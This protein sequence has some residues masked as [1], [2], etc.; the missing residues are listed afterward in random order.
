MAAII[1]APTRGSAAI[2]VHTRGTPTGLLTPSMGPSFWAEP[3]ARSAKNRVPEKHPLRVIRRVVNEVLVALD[4]EFPKL[5]AETGRP[6]IAPERLL[7]C[8]G[9]AHGPMRVETV[10]ALRVAQKGLSWG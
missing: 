6:S 9:Q 10:H 7:P 5:Y 4:A 1:K 3:G 8:V 2:S